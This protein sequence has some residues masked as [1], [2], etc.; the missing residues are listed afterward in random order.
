MRSEA[1]GKVI[2]IAG[3]N[4]TRFLRD[5]FNYFFVFVF[6]L[7]LILILGLAFGSGAKPTVGVVA[8]QDA[9]A[10][11]FV[12]ALEADDSLIVERQAD[13]AELRGRVERGALA[14]GVILPV[15]LAERLA[16]GEDVEVQFL[17][18][19]AGTGRS[20]QYTV[21]GALS[22]VAATV[23]AARYVERGTLEGLSGS[24]ALVDAAAAAT[25][26]I[27]VEQQWIGGGSGGDLDVAFAIG[28][29]SQLVLFVFLT[30]LTSASALILSR[31]LGVSRRM[32]ASPTHPVTIVLGEALGRYL[33]ALFQGVYIIL[34]TAL[35][36]GVVWGDLVASLLVLAVFA[37][38]AAGAGMLLGSVFET[39]QQASGVAIM[40]GLGLAALGGAMVPLEV[41]GPT[42]RAV[43]RF[44]PHSWAVDAYAQLLRRGAGL[45][46]VLPQLGVLTGFAVLFFALAAWRFRARLLE[47]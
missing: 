43:A 34:A 7:G 17:S 35:L 44:V 27:T 1:L 18:V 21:S 2:A 42:M 30:G 23:R 46:D 40:V 29:G 12:A 15:D 6:P 20:L 32:L 3:S 39:D 24:L 28:A 33:V 31:T 37:A 47:G 16:A 10:Q 8:G 13:A 5:R 22:E 19:G 14:A 45:V 9:T 41:F 4:L 38:V 25:P 11:R 26:A 36:F